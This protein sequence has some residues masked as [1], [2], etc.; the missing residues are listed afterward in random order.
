MF[1]LEYVKVKDLFQC[2]WYFTN[3]SVFIVEVPL[4]NF[5]VENPDK[6]LPKEYRRITFPL[7]L[8]SS[9]PVWP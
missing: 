4:P 3:A 2:R 8:D 6:L 9:Y 5:S 7:D 1:M